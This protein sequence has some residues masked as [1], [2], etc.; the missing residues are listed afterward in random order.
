MAWPAECLGFPGGNQTHLKGCGEGVIQGE[1]EVQ[2][3]AWPEHGGTA[4]VEEVANIYQAEP[5]LLRGQLT[6]G[7]V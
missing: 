7:G 2:P 1:Y 3:S 5:G 6:R 4:S